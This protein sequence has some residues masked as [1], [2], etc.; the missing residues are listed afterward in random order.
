MIERPYPLLVP[1]IF[2]QRYVRK[3]EFFMVK[4]EYHAFLR[5]FCVERENHE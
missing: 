3:I 2:L 1:G 5:D 4:S